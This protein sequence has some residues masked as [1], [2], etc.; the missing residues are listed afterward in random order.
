MERFSGEVKAKGK[1]FSRTISRTFL[2][3]SRKDPRKVGISAL[4]E[5]PLNKGE[6]NIYLL[7]SLGISVVRHRLLIRGPQVRVLPGAPKMTRG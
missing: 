6:I 5:N 7:I 4:S 1:I 3:L 2:S